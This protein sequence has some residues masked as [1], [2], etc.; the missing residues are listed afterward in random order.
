MKLDPAKEPRNFLIQL[1]AALTQVMNIEET[2]SIC[3]SVAENFVAEL[4]KRYGDIEK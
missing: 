1:M 3:F 2:P 4:E